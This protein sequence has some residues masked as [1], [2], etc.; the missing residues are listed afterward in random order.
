M[1]R[2]SS[3]LITTVL[4]GTIGIAPAFAQQAATPASVNTVQPSSSTTGAVKQEYSEAQQEAATMMGHVGIASIALSYNIT[5]EA[6]NNVQQALTIAQKLERQTVQLN[7]DNL[8][9]GKLKYHSASGTSQDY[10]LPVM[11]NSFIVSD[12]DSEYLKSKQPKAAEEDAQVINTNVLLN[13]KQVTD[14]LE[15]AATAISA[16]NYGDAQAA[17]SNAEQSTF[18]D[19]IISELPLATARDNLGL[20]RALVKSKDYDGASFALNHAKDALTEYQQTADS[21]KASQSKQLQ[22]EISALQSEIAKDKPSVI[23]SAERHIDNWMHKIETM[24]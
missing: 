16:K 3:L 10:W 23:A 18:T 9:F 6:A 19:Q 11:N 24:M 17:L 20:A 12:L 21:G 15:K 5:D 4:S 2:L 14:S 1:K 13:V 8:K 22:T 7:A